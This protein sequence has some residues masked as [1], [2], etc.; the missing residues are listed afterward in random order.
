MGEIPKADHPF[1]GEVKHLNIG[2]ETDQKKVINKIFISLIKKRPFSALFLTITTLGIYPFALYKKAKRT[3]KN[4]LAARKINYYQKL[5]SQIETVR[6]KHPY[7]EPRQDISKICHEVMQEKADDT[8]HFNQ[9]F[10]SS[11]LYL[12]ITTPPLDDQID[13]TS[14]VD[15][16]PEHAKSWTRIKK[17]ARSNEFCYIKN[18]NKHYTALLRSHNLHADDIHERLSRTTI[19]RSAPHCLTKLKSLS[20]AFSEI[21]TAFEEFNELSE[22]NPHLHKALTFL[23]ELKE[24]EVALITTYLTG[25]NGD[26][27]EDLLRH[28][29]TLLQAESSLTS[30]LT[31]PDHTR[32]P[33]ILPA[34]K[35]TFLT[36]AHEAFRSPNP[37]IDRLSK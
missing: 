29:L 5:L 3:L 11:D 4:A 31:D 26:P 30:L 9:V 13:A 2:N 12:F 17:A 14:F 15:Q 35:L 18:I 16:G 34:G 36:E 7:Q 8:L 27:P 22:A 20:L 21:N 28:L 24:E 25:I 32:L 6:V 1:L 19:A 33:L 37:L 23:L 10:S